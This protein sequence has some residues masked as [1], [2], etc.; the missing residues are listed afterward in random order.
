MGAELV[1]F[2][3]V[4]DEHLPENLDGMLL[5]GG[6]PELNG[7][8]LER[9]ES[10]KTEIA[11]AVSGGMPCM[12][13]CGGFMYLHEQMEDMNGINRRTCGVISGKCFRTPKFRLMNSI[14]LIQKTAAVTFM[15]QNPSASGDG[16][17]S[18]VPEA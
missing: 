17:V 15:H 16:I 9:N 11:Q 18:T 8:A 7:E 12:A 2:S 6:Y 14:I 13:E 5:Y 4:H 3:P 10:M 1:E